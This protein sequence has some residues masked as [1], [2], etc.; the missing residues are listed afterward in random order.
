VSHVTVTDLHHALAGQRLALL[1][2]RSGRGPAFV[3]VELPDGRRRTIRRAATDL[4][5]PIKGQDVG[6]DVPFIN[7]R[8]LL[9]LARYLTGTLTA[10][11]E[12]V[13]CD[14]HPPPAPPSPCVSAPRSKSHK[15]AAA[16]AEP[17][18]RDANPD[19]SS[20]RRDA[21]THSG[22]PRDHHPGEPPC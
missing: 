7:V 19:R 14:D 4:V 16:L 17:A 11:P 3:V 10:S 5:A 21:A 22:S 9:P 6:L 15:T 2:L 18:G 12:E 1:A 13:I 8:T 20:A